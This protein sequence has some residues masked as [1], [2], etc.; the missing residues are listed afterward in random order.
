MNIQRGAQSPTSGSRSVEELHT[1][2]G[3]DFGTST[4]VVSVVHQTENGV[5]TS[6][7]SIVQRTRRGTEVKDHKVPTCIAYSSIHKEMYIGAGAYDARFD[8]RV[9][10][11]KNVWFEFKTLLGQDVGPRYVESVLDGKDGRPKLETAVDAASIFLTYIREQ[12]EKEI[13]T[14]GLPPKLKYV[15]SVPAS[16]EANQRKDLLEALDNAGISATGE[17]M[18]IDEPNAAFLSYLEQSGRATPGAKKLV[19]PDGASENLLVFDFGAGTCDISLLEIGRKESG[20]VFSKNLAIS[21]YTEIGGKDIDQ[22]VAELLLASAT[23]VESADPKV[24]DLPKKSK[25]RLKGQLLRAAE[26]LKVQLCKDVDFTYKRAGESSAKTLQSRTGAVPQELKDHK[27]RV[28]RNAGSSLSH[29]QFEGIMKPYVTGESGT[30]VMNPTRSALSSAGLEAEDITYVLMVGGSAQNPWVLKALQ[31]KFPDAEFLIP[32]DMQALVSQGAALHSYYLH[33]LGQ[34]LIKPITGPTINLRLSNGVMETLVPSGTEIPYAGKEVHGFTP[35]HDGQKVL[36]LPICLTTEDYV[37][38]VLR[39]EPQAGSAFNRRDK[40]SLAV[41]ISAD[42]TLHVAAKVSSGEAVVTQL[43]PYASKALNTRQRLAAEAR[44]RFNID[45]RRTGGTPTAQ[46]MATFAG[47]LA[48]ADERLDAAELMDEAYHADPRV[49]NLN[50]LA[51]AWANAGQSEKA[52]AYYRKAFEQGEIY[53]GVNL[54]ANLRYTDKSQYRELLQK[55]YSMD[56]HNDWVLYN[57]GQMLKDD[58]DASWQK[59]WR[60]ALGIYTARL[61]SNTLKAEDARRA[62]TVAIALESTEDLKTIEAYLLTVGSND[63]VFDEANTIQKAANTE[64][65]HTR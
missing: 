63:G 35:Q 57:Y 56:A 11:E 30:S 21:H 29:Q 18:L 22:S 39:I 48:K 60:K 20:E 45:V 4:T 46:Q 17:S 47:A 40:I 34:R 16:F 5:S 59:H 65:T 33:A 25:Q 19:I 8:N 36:E 51:V 50:N 3:L 44:K 9:V 14:L 32:S 38:Q 15:V 64:L 58:G 62:K 2:V 52:S 31:R 37:L 1:F 53:A 26:E 61:A 55:A 12:I 7:L 24:T 6:P 10:P 49:V 54:A 41:K 27:N 13:A 43:N 42:K 28:Y 23:P